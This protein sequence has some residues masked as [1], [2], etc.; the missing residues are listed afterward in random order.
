MLCK[1]QFMMCSIKNKQDLKKRPIPKI[2]FVK[3][4]EISK[5]AKNRRTF[6]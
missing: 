5:A 6:S 1:N 2:K 3:E 4:T